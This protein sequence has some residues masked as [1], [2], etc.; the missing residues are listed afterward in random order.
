[1]LPTIPIPV[2][3]ESL[4][5][6][7]AEVRA[8]VIRQC[9]DQDLREI[10]IHL[11]SSSPRFL[12]QEQLVRLLHKLRALASCDETDEAPDEPPDEPDTRTVT[13]PNLQT[14][15]NMSSQTY[16]ER[17]A[18][19]SPVQ[20]ASQDR[21]QPSPHAENISSTSIPQVRPQIQSTDNDRDTAVSLDSFHE[22]I[23][24]HSPT[25]NPNMVTDITALEVH[26]KASDSSSDPPEG[27][28]ARE[29]L[30]PAGSPNVVTNITALE[31]HPKTSDSSSGPPE[32]GGARKLPKSSVVP[33]STH[34]SPD[35]SASTSRCA[36]PISFRQTLLQ[37]TST[38]GDNERVPEMSVCE[39]ERTITDM[40]HGS[41]PPG[42]DE[43][44][45]M[46][47]HVSPDNIR[48]PKRSKQGKNGQ[49]AE[50][51][52]EK[53]VDSLPSPN[54]RRATAPLE[55]EDTQC[56]DLSNDTDSEL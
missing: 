46:V 42:D 36:S 9:S 13:P 1:M 34:V 14:H 2:F 32:G 41:A 17:P 28:G 24:V 6:M 43:K 4:Q 5:H 40:A 29:I 51:I 33:K 22:G 15:A 26:P 7:K 52:A 38:P 49:I 44:S 53:Q 55:A 37:N 39:P 48:S 16:I 30:S 11:I 35:Q 23:A 50:N 31:I 54:L 21:A 12:L 25:G 45:P 20:Q 18:R 27:G 3:L 47:A 19:I 8:N 10:I 56:A